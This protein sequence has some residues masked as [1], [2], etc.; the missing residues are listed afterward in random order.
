MIGLEGIGLSDAL[1]QL[2]KAHE[3]RIVSSAQTALILITIVCGFFI[4]R[5][6]TWELYGRVLSNS[7]AIMF[8]LSCIYFLRQHG[9]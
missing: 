8:T 7:V 9:V 5:S 6:I 4:I 1:D 3:S 2:H